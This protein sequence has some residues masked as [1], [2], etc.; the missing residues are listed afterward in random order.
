MKKAASVPQVRLT[1]YSEQRT[2]SLKA[3]KNNNDDINLKNMVKIKL[4]K[5]FC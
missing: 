3:L 4:K 1:E 5:I 2:Y